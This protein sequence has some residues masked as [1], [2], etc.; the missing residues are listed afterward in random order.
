MLFDV[1]G[2]ENGFL[3]SYYY[4]IDTEYGFSSLA[5]SRINTDLA[6]KSAA[7]T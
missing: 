7:L 3:G 5:L 2:P 1:S 6:P 4:V